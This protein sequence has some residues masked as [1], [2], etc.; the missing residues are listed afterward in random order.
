M[1][2]KILAL[3]S[4]DFGTAPFERMTQKVI[5]VVVSFCTEL[6]K[7]DPTTVEPSASTLEQLRTV[8]PSLAI[9]SD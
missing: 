5:D 2:M 1:C 8:E 4:R 9:Y 3:D 6:R 7:R